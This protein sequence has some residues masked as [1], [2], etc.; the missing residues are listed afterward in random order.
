MPKKLILFLPYKASMWDS[1]E[2]IY[3]AAAKD[4]ECEAMVMPVPYFV[5]KSMRNREL[6]CD[7]KLFPQ[8]LKIIDYKKFNIAKAKPHTIYIHNAYDNTNAITEIHP[9][10]STAKLKKHTQNLVYVPY[11]L[12]NEKSTKELVNM[13]ALKNV[14]K[15]IAASE[16]AKK[17]FAKFNPESKILTLGSPKVDAIKSMLQNP[18]QIPEE[19]KERAKGKIVVFYNT[20]VGFIKQALA[21]GKLEQTFDY[22]SKSPNL[23]LIWR[24]HP[25]SK[26][27]TQT[28]AKEEFGKYELLVKKYKEENIGIFDDTPT[29]HAA[30]ALS[31]LYYGDKSSLVPLYGL[32]GKPVL[33]Q[34]FVANTAKIHLDLISQ[35]ENNQWFCHSEFNGLFAANTNSK[36]A[37][38]IGSFPNEALHKRNLYLAPVLYKNK[39]VFAPHSANGIGIYNIQTG[40]LSTLPLPELEKPIDKGI[41]CKFSKAVA[42]GNSVFFVG[43]RYLGFLELNMETMEI[44]RHRK[45]RINGFPCI[46]GSKIFCAAKK[47]TKIACFSME[48]KTLE[49]A[50]TPF[51]E[52]FSMS[53]SNGTVSLMPYKKTSEQLR[54]SFEPYANDKI[55]KELFSHPLDLATDHNAFIRTECFP[56]QTLD[57]L[58]KNLEQASLLAN[59]QTTAF[60]SIFANS[61]GTAGKK[62]HEVFQHNG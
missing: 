41:S 36:N 18:P 56:L 27:F 35:I 20:A 5:N 33:I 38:F 17:N 6:F 44:H 16:G 7:A 45:L 37:H 31:H 51:K 46:V 42:F 32:T 15:I 21:M 29:F 24:P 2:S 8:H 4:P 10:Y 19:W 12:V 54:I 11:C 48:I 1:L 22:F 55:S 28:I 30:F 62:I 23:L 52:P 13:P 14:S 34:N 58:I 3:L 40:E 25:L 43:S 9:A 60:E 61:D 59:L 57:A 47:W 50:D 39:L 49:L 53:F 26:E